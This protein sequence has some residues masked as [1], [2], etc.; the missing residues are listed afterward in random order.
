MIEGIQVRIDGKKMVIPI[1]KAREL[2]GDLERLFGK[3]PNI[4]YPFWDYKEDP[5][6][7]P[8]STGDISFTDKTK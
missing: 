1:T 5:F 3:E 4:S 7:Y 2:Y 6:K 8:N